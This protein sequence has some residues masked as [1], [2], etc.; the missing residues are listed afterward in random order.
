MLSPEKELRNDKC[1]PMKERKSIREKRDH[2]YNM[3][4]IGGEIRSWEKE[5]IK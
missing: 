5:N 1:R 4:G 2:Q 3:E